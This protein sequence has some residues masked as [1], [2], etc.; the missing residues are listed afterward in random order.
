MATMSNEQTRL[1]GPEFRR[2]PYASYAELRQHAP[3]N[4]ATLPDGQEVWVVTR[5][6]D[7][8]AVLKDERFVVDFHNAYDPDQIAR[9]PIEFREDGPAGRSML[10]SDAP[11]HTRLRALVSKAFTP[12]VVEQLRPRI[13][14]IADQ[15][16]DAAQ[17]QGRID[18]IEA[19]AF[20]LPIIVI[21]ELL[22]VPTEDQQQF[23]Q[24]SNVLVSGLGSFE[25]DDERRGA[26][27]AFMGYL[28][29]LIERRRANPGT[30]LIS[31]LVQVEERG[32]TLSEAELL[33]MILLLLVA[34]HETTVN[35]IGN[36]TLALLR[37]P[38]QL[39]LLRAN[40]DLIKGAIEELLR[41]TN[42]VQ[43]TFRFVREDL[44]LAGQ[45]LRR[46]ERVMVV[47]AAANHDESQMSE[48]ERLD[49]TR[50]S[51]R[52]MS[53]GQGMH[54]CLGA[55]LARLE[56]QIAIGTLLRRLPNLHLA[57]AADDLAWRPGFVLRGLHEL[58]IAF[59]AAR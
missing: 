59:D 42:P 51:H 5:Y 35:L 33:S 41:Y 14:Q 22:G 36:G 20:P 31:A 19:Y 10:M 1:F 39:D 16:I 45:Q 44:T 3:I 53:F 57:V 6:A 40:P 37:H 48:A 28:H 15:L 17:A 29:A 49:I 52:H 43:T 50:A 21:T 18:L 56:A 24:W 8:S 47:L 11:N 23:R 9:L 46:G 12:R 58:P 4:R 2:D 25:I 38:D 55:P 13:Q 30:D 27:Q 7:V 26:I 34:G 54:Y 32:D